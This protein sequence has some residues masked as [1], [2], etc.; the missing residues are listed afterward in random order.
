MAMEGWDGYYKRLS[1]AI[2]SE[3]NRKAADAAALRSAA[4]ETDRKI[5]KIEKNPV[6]RALRFLTGGGRSK[7][8]LPVN[9]DRDTG[10]TLSKEL[11][12]PSSPEY[13]R[14]FHRQTNPYES[15]KESH[16]LTPRHIPCD[17]DEIRVV[18]LAGCSGINPLAESEGRKYILFL[19]EDTYV[20]EN[21]EHRMTAFMDGEPDCSF[22]YWDEDRFD[23]GRGIGSD[24][25]FKPGPSPDT[26]ISFMY[27]GACVMVREEACRD[28]PWE[29]EWDPV[30]N[31]YVLLLRLLLTK[32]VKTMG[33][34]PEV[35][36]GSVRGFREFGAHPDLSGIKEKIFRETGT[37]VSFK[38][39]QDPLITHAL[40]EPQG[41]W[42]LVSVIIPS[43]DHPDIL[44]RAV[45]SIRTG[46]D[47][48]SYE[49]IVVDNGSTDMGR[50]AYEH[51]S[52]IYDFNYI[53]FKS[54]FNFSHSCNLGAEKSRG[55][56]LLFLNDDTE[57]IEKDWM[58]NLA[59]Q[60]LRPW[61]GAAGAR[62]LYEGT[63][64]I[65]HAGVTNM[66]IGPSHK[67]ATLTDERSYYH[68]VNRYD[69]NVLAVT[70]ACM[71]IRREV[72]DKACGFDEELAVAYND[73]DLCMT[74][75]EMGYF[76]VLRNDSVMW[77]DESLS[78]GADDADP[79]KTD[80]LYS[81]EQRLYSKHADFKGRDPFYSPFLSQDTVYYE[82]R[83]DFEWNDKKL[84][85]KRASAP[86][87]QVHE[88]MKLTVDRAVLKKD[89]D[90]AV[91][92]SVLVEGWAYVPDR[93][94]SDFE[95]TVLL[96][97]TQGHTLAFRAFPR[98]RKDVY[99]ALDSMQNC[100]LTAF[101]ARISPG[102][103]PKGTY[104][105]GLSL[106]AE[107]LVYVTWSDREVTL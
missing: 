9:E 58:R 81:E 37:G 51:L 71:M 7:D 96:R 43:K 64:L 102:D 87:G 17:T 101:T 49:I 27:T 6:Y 97:D 61:T 73:I 19:P 11:R 55:E 66:A 88:G 30:Q 1:A 54:E 3:N 77:H 48:S 18:S 57:V 60:T 100:G 92:V 34:I 56:L 21:A 86:E 50:K 106:K 85:S 82:V 72:F 36:S 2:R 80:R 42:P 105:V 10:K 12:S 89:P 75:T 95:K 53:Y 15:L 52:E 83:G 5:A 23:P 62:L 46:T 67:L 94:N 59:C 40:Y 14:E 41:P 26:L 16:A 79:E 25:V 39:A 90:P 38:P 76:N 65:Q 33:Y 28:L 68:G 35:L 93:D 104:N 70:G 107:G 8:S 63:D 29:A 45:A 99:R 4:E 84:L 13:E 20:T 69:R 24:P 74:L 31:I 47:Y 91:P 32:G 78:R 98:Y 44:E 103:V 22:V